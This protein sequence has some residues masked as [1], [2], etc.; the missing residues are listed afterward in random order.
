MNEPLSAAQCFEANAIAHARFTVQR[1]EEDRIAKQIMEDSIASKAVQ[2][3]RYSLERFKE[4]LRNEDA[5]KDT[6]MPLTHITEELRRVAAEQVVQMQKDNANLAEENARL[7]RGL[8]ILTKRIEELESEIDKMRGE[9][10]EAVPDL[11]RI[12][13]T[14]R[15]FYFAPVQI[16]SLSPVWAL[17]LDLNPDIVEQRR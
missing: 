9:L 11:E 14:L 6:E 16:A 10:V 7:R 2:D 12:A 1:I 8:S 13:L 5:M 3:P 15:T 4:R 17:A